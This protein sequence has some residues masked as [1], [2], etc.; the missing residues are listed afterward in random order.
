MLH[1]GGGLRCLKRTDVV[2]LQHLIIGSGIVG[3]DPPM[4]SALST[5]DYRV[6]RGRKLGASGGFKP[7]DAFPTAPSRILDI[8]RSWAPG[9]RISQLLGFCRLT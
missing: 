6:S 5:S 1:S 3:F 7:E 4:L 2:Y 8:N 9:L